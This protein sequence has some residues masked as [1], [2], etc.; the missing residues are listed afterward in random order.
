MDAHASLEAQAQA[1][2]HRGAQSG[3]V[4]EADPHCVDG[5]L[6][7]RGARRN[8]K[9][10]PH[11]REL[12]L[13]RRPRH[14][15]VAGEIRGAERHS[16]HAPRTR[17]VLERAGAEDAVEARKAR[18]RLDDRHEV[19]SARRQSALA[20]EVGDQP[21]DRA[22]IRSRLHLGEHD[23][24]DAGPDDRHDIRQA[25]LRP[26]AV[27]AYVAFACAGLCQRFDHGFPRRRLLR[28]RNRIFQVEDHGVR[29][30]GQS[31]FHAPWMI[32]RGK[33]KRAQH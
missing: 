17:I 11:R 16:L 8:Y 12:L 33:Q 18:R 19:D 25:P 7:A 23:A 14:A 15:D 24:I 22:Q 1:A 20:L 5:R 6:D 9:V 4:P 2:L 30:Q 26:D 10:D 13:A 29:A 28:D 31:L 27:D 32:S 21:V 3:R